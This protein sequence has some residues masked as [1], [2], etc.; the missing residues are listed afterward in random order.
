MQR[1]LNRCEVLLTYAAVVATFLMMCLTTADAAGRYVFGRPV[2]GAYEITE[3][4]LMVAAVFLAVSFA[5]RQGAYIRV[6]FLVDRLPRRAR[7][8]INHVVQVASLLYGV[9]LVVAT[10]QQALRNIASGTTLSSVP[11]PLAPAYAI[12]PVGLFFMSLSILLDIWQVGKG[13][14]PLFSAEAPTA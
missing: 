6:T 2:T 14:A 3:K 5:Y 7:G 9:L 1:V 10:V 12:V 4:Y 8:P 11:L 13:K